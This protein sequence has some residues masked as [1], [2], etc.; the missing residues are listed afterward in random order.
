MLQNAVYRHFNFLAW[1]TGFSHET[2][3]DDLVNVPAK[4]KLKILLPN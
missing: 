2:D 1:V 4:A 3:V